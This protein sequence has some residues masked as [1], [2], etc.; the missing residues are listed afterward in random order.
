MLFSFSSTV[1]ALTTT[2][3]T[4]IQYL[5][6]KNNYTATHF[7]QHYNVPYNKENKDITHST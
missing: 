5:I 1:A 3:Q 6:E 4:N 2:K 7:Y